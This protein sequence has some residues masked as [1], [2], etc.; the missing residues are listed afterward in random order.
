MPMSPKL[1]RPRATSANPLSFSGLAAW[2]DA[3]DAASITLNS[4]TVSEWR[5]KSGNARHLTQATAARQP[6]YQSSAQN[7][8][9]AI[10]FANTSTQY[11]AYSSGMFTF[12]GA[13]TVFV[14]IKS[15]SRSTENFGSFLSEGTGETVRSFVTLA[16]GVYNTTGVRPVT[17]IYGPHG[18]RAVTAIDGTAPTVLQ[19]KWDNWSTHRGNAG[20]LLGVNNDG[21]TT[22]SYGSL[23]PSDFTG[24]TRQF[25]VGLTANVVL[26]GAALTSTVCEIV[27]YTVALTDTQRRAIRAYL[28][29]KWGVVV[30]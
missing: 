4:T 28:G 21:V 15:A 1:M 12:T 25:Q 27:A 20:T 16:P 10:A 29:K 24:N 30:A 9:A 5:D 2:W 19:W 26:S 3:S 7:G 11:L 23:G 22:E 13:G 17:D 18:Q 6:T 8:L 14:V